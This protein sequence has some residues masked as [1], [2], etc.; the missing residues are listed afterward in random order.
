MSAPVTLMITQAG[1]DAL[2]NAQSGATEPVRVTQVGLTET[3][4]VIAPT[5]DALPGEFKRLGAVSGT[6]VSETIIHMTATD[7]STDIYELRGLGLYLEDGTL[8]AVHA[9]PTPIFRKISIASFLLALDIAFANGAGEI[10]FGS[11]TFLLPP[12]SETVA[13]VAEI[14]DDAQADEGIDD[15]TI[16][17]PKKLKRRLDALANALGLSLDELAQALATLMARTISGGGLATGGGNLSAS[18]TITVTG[19]DAPSAIAML[20]NDVVITPAALRAALG[21]ISVQGGQLVTG[22][23]AITGSHTLNVYPAVGAD[24]IAG[25]RTDVVATPAAIRALTEYLT[26][27]GTGLVTGGGN[28]TAPRTLEVRAATGGEAIAGDANDCAVTPASLRAVQS[29]LSIGGT[30]L[31][32]GGGNLT[33]SRTVDVRAATATDVA[34]GAATDCAITPAA[35]SGLARTLSGNGYAVIPGTG[36][37]I[38]QWGRFSAAANGT[39]TTLFP[40]SFPTACFSIVSDGGVAG[41]NDS[42]DNPPVL[43]DGS[44]T[45]SGF[46]VFSADDGAAFRRYLAVGI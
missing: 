11:S 42:Q 10:S 22:G 25:Q 16:I 1:L 18:R 6:S 12:A 24:L 9:Q 23:G 30:G 13:G 29:A 31:V 43:I 45:Q 17:S 5:I 40:I 3:A 36:G 8:F 37:L 33:A 34:A 46:S 15:A 44:V 4:F 35:L 38:L 26:I 27:G 7:A 41:G 32:T 19:S 14:A 39:T 21:N 28:L 20:R 2:V